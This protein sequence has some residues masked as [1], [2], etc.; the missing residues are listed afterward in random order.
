MFNI[1][2]GFIAFL[3]S[4]PCEAAP[5]KVLTATVAQDQ[6]SASAVDEVAF[7]TGEGNA[8]F[9]SATLTSKLVPTGPLAWDLDS[10]YATEAEAEAGVAAL[11]AL[12]AIEN[13][14]LQICGGPSSQIQPCFRLGFGT[15][16]GQIKSISYRMRDLAGPGLP[17]LYSVACAGE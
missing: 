11:C 15:F 17:K 9:T 4:S 8:V 5:F 16:H 7:K 6:L 13:V 12:K 14:D 1:I 10:E 3:I 2:V